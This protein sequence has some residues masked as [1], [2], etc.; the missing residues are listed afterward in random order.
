MSIRLDSTSESTLRCAYPVTE[1]GSD[2]E[3]MVR[4]ME[5]KD[6]W[7]LDNMVQ[8]GDEPAFECDVERMERLHEAALAAPPED[9]SAYGADGGGQ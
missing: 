6:Q 5:W 1:S 4:A 9:E 7:R 2:S 3:R 8:W